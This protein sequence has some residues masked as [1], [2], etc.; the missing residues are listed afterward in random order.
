MDW[1]FSIKALLA[2]IPV[3]LLVATGFFA[4]KRNIIREDANTSLSK[5]TIDICI[6]CFILYNILKND[7]LRDVG[8]ALTSMS[9][10]AMG[11]VIGLCVSLFIARYI[12]RLKI[13]TNL[14]TFSASAGVQN[15]GFFVLSILFLLFDTAGADSQIMGIALIHNVGCDLMFWSFCFLLVA[16]GMPFTLRIFLKAPILAVFFGLF[17]VWTHI[18]ELVPDTLMN[19][20]Y[21]IG[22]SA[23]PLSLILFGSML[24]ESW[25][26]EGFDFKL[27]SLGVL[28]RMLVLP[29]IIL[30]FAYILPVSKEMKYIMLLQSAAPSSMTVAVLAKYFEGNPKLAIHIIFATSIV[31][32]IT[33][34]FWLAIGFNFIIN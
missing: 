25:S 13:G 22:N 6:P 5:L 2:T 34:P 26:F 12:M 21:L 33:L 20:L 28:I 1:S 23:I 10:G 32:L 8:L 14:R 3:Y 7:K 24:Y 30:G 29:A 11:L 4:R 16:E 15:Y 31:A 18:N 19:T 9:I 27:V 17:C